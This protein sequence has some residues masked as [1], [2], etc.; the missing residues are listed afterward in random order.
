MK[1]KKDIEDPIPKDL[2]DILACPLCRA[3]LEYTKNKDGVVCSSC[4]VKYPIKEGIP[5][6]LSPKNR[7]RFKA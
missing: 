5:I 2:F 4:G 1:Y 3:D 6:L 7:K